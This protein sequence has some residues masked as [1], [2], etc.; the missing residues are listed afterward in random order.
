MKQTK[1]E[2]TIANAFFTIL[3]IY[4]IESLL[5]AIVYSTNFL[6]E[7]FQ[8][9]IALFTIVAFNVYLDKK[10]FVMNSFDRIFE[11]LFVTSTTCIIVY[12]HEASIATTTMIILFFV[13]IFL[14][15]FTK[16][17]NLDQ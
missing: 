3:M 5:F 12:C 11:T 2:Q 13:S 16:K 4:F 15:I 17:L 8:S 7:S 14:N 10:S 6:R 1:L 9:F